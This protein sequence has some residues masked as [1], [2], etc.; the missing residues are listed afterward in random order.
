MFKMKQPNITMRYPLI[1]G[2]LFTI[3]LL[4]GCVM[5]A[6]LST[7][8]TATPEAATDAE[9]L[10]PLTAIELA[11]GA[12]LQV[13][14]STNIVADVVSQVGGDQIDLL[15]LIPTGADPHSFTPTPQDLIVL[16]QT[17]VIFINGLQLEESLMPMLESLDNAVPIVSVNAGVEIA[18]FGPS[19]V[20]HACKHMMDGPEVAVGAVADIAATTAVTGTHVRLDVTVPTAAPSYF[21]YRAE[22]AGKYLFYADS[23]VILTLRDAD[24]NEAPAETIMDAAALADCLAFVTAFVFDLVEGDNV[25]S[26]HGVDGETVRFVVETAE[27]EHEHATHEDEDH[28]DEDHAVE[29]HAGEEAEVHDH[30]AAET[31]E[32]EGHHHHHGGVDPHTWFSVH[33]VEQW[34]E[35]IEE[36][37][38]TLDPANA[39][40]YAANADAYRAELVALKIELGAMVAELPVEQRKLVTDHDAFGYFADA[41]DFE[42]IGTVIPSLST[43]ASPSAND[44]A[45]L[46]D[47]I[48]AEGVRAIFVGTT[49]NPTLM[50]Q[51]AADTGATVVSIYTGALSDADG[52]APTYLDLMRYNMRMIVDALK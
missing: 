11:D 38:S 12:R 8:S 9:V 46:Q 42:I 1:L 13:I 4:A 26:L 35:N 37:L 18:E 27:G 31:G 47:Q 22:E 29:D 52:P 14:A 41:Y 6:P 25:L 50:E 24:G 43:M 49:V 28:A 33:A 48:E 15:P 34:V 51:L 5:P 40:T 23:P 17:Q 44:L 45:T 2:A 20:E 10:P 32:E 3:V 21:V 36:V 19:A 39:D 30:H 16:N 7:A